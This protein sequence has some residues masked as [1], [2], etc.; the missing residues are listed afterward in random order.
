MFLHFSY[1]AT[2]FNSIS[3]AYKNVAV[4]KLLLFRLACNQRAYFCI[5]PVNTWTRAKVVIFIL[6]TNL[7]FFRRWSN[8]T[9]MMAYYNILLYRTLHC[10]HHGEILEIMS[11][12]P[13][14]TLMKIPFKPKESRA[15]TLFLG[16]RITG[17]VFVPP[18]TD[19]KGILLLRKYDILLRS[20]FF[21]RDFGD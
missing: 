13:V 2:Q 7:A 18:Q 10:V 17:N 16:S 1:R 20:H 12:Y 8:D 19:S 14:N 9:S 6:L 3:M 21:I 4:S 11:L 15:Y 5:P